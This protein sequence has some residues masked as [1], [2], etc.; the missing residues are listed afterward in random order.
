MARRKTRT[1][2][3]SKS[4]LKFVGEKMEASIA[5]ALQFAMEMF[6]SKAMIV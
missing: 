4:G 3:T 2:T 6:F 1:L 5:D